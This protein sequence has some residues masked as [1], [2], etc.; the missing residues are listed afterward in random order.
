MHKVPR[1]PL[2]NDFY[3][4]YLI[5]RKSAVFVRRV[6]KHYA[7][8]TLE[9]LAGHDQR[10]TRR[11]AVLAIGLIGDFGSNATLGRALVDVDRGVPHDRR[12]RHP[13]ALVPLGNESAI[14][15]G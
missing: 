7:I 15:A 14:A 10:L 2:I 8:G 1:I 9:R 11:A 5:D 4:Q 6:A 12:Q 3:H 13:P